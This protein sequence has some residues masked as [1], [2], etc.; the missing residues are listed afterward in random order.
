ML[1]DVR[2]YLYQ[3]WDIDPESKDPRILLEYIKRFCKYCL[4][5]GRQN[6]P[7]NVEERIMHER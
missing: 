7:K 2:D 3:L 1:Q 5:Y 4:L 6:D